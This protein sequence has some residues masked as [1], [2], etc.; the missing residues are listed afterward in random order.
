MT[1]NDNYSTFVDIS[2]RSNVIS[3]L[4][5]YF[6]DFEVSDPMR[7]GNDWKLRIKPKRCIGC[8][9]M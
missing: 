8:A 7:I 4:S 2:N 3:L 5:R 1:K 9:T 6:H